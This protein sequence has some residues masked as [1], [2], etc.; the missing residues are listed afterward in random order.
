MQLPIIRN[1]ELSLWI[2]LD[3]APEVQEKHAQT[4]STN[5]LL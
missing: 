1:S 3:R 5:F 2:L 4:L